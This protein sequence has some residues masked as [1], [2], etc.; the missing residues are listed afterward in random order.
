MRDEQSAQRPSSPRVTRRLAT[1]CSTQ[2]GVV[3]YFSMSFVLRSTDSQGCRGRCSCHNTLLDC[4]D[5]C[6]VQNYSGSSIL[7]YPIG[8]FPYVWRFN[9][10]ALL[11]LHF[12][13]AIRTPSFTVSIASNIAS[14]IAWLIPC[15]YCHV[16]PASLL[17][18]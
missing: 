16:K 18:R 8:L 2:D 5:F 14:T 7:S 10:S 15:F 3:P 13:D 4:L 9:S 6:F 12:D 11:L 1:E 17:F